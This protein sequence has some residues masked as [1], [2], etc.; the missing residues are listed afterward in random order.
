VR[1]NVIAIIAA[2]GGVAAVMIHTFGLNLDGERVGG[3]VGAVF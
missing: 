1:H 3:G 2:A